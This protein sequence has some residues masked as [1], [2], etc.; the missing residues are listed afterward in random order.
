ME[1]QPSRPSS[2]RTN[3]GRR[4]PSWGGRLGERRGNGGGGEGKSRPRRPTMG[5]SGCALTV[6]AGGGRGGG[7]AAARAVADRTGAPRPHA[8]APLSHPGSIPDDDYMAD[9]ADAESAAASDRSG[10]DPGARSG[11]G[12]P[13]PAGPPAPHAPPA[14]WDAYFTRKRAIPVPGRGSFVVYEA[15][16]AAAAAAGVASATTAPPSPPRPVVLCFHGAGYTALSWALV[17]RRLSGAAPVRV[18]AFDARGH[19]ETATRDDGDLSAAT[20]AADA[21]ALWAALVAECPAPPPVVLLGHG[22]GGS[23]AVR[24]AAGGAF[25][26]ALAGVA[27]VD[28]TLW[29]AGAPTQPHILSVLGGRPPEFASYGAALEFATR[30]GRCR[31]PEAVLVSFVSMLRETTDA[32]GSRWVWRTPL[33]GA[34]RDHWDGWYAGLDAAFLALRAPKLLLLSHRRPLE[35]SLAV[36]QAQGKLQVLALPQAGYAIHEDEPAMLADALKEFL[37]HFRVIDPHAAPPNADPSK[38]G[39]EAGGAGDLI[40]MSG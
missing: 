21:G 25:G 14:R 5:L 34:A 16:G 8:P 26:P 15:V 11:A 23:V 18:L 3:S 27:L 40:G 28:V 6:W 9:F 22:M 2:T 39:G 32:A 7:G 19:G 12:T 10:G 4:A 30:S 31:N 13:A 1:S 17:A 35:K 37:T 29:D 38:A 24:A 33:E 20:L 36:A